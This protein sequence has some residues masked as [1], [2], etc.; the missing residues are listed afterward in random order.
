MLPNPNPRSSS[1]VARTNATPAPPY[2]EAFDSALEADD[3][4]AYG[5]DSYLP[6]QQHAPTRPPLPDEQSGMSIRDE[7]DYGRGGRTL[8]VA[9]E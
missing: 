1:P 5:V 7:D 8:K 3:E 4:D 6:M 2:S 9:N